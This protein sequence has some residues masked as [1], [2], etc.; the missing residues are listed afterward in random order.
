[1][2]EADS[3]V[4]I[5]KENTCSKVDRFWKTSTLFVNKSIRIS[6]V[7]LAIDI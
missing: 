7:I 6:C 3:L 5:Y 1:M 2:W 4:C